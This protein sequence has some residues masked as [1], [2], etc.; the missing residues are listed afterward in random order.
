MEFLWKSPD[1]QLLE[2]ED[3]EKSKLDLK[4]DLPDR[5]M[6]NPWRFYLSKLLPWALTVLFASVALVEHLARTQ[7]SSLGSYSAGWKADFGAYNPPESLINID[8]ACF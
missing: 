6:K 2:V 7:V 5:K 3:D 4:R 8:D 1:Y